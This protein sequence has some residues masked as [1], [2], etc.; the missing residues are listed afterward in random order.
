M[1]FW[2][3]S[4]VFEGLGVLGF[5]RGNE[6]RFGGFGLVLGFGGIWNIWG[7]SDLGYLGFW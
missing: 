6:G 7:H 2:G 1:E 3:F 4:G 5:W